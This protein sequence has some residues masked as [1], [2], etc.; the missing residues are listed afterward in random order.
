VQFPGE[1]RSFLSVLPRQARGK[2]RTYRTFT[3]KTIFSP[4]QAWDTHRE[5]LKKE[6][7]FSTQVIKLL[8]DDVALERE[9]CMFFAQD[10]SSAPAAAAT[11]VA[12]AAA[13]AAAAAG[14]KGAG[15]PAGGSRG[16]GGRGAGAG[17]GARPSAGGALGP[18]PATPSPR[19]LSAPSGGAPPHLSSLLCLRP[20]S[21]SIVRYCGNSVLLEH[22]CTSVLRCVHS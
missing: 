18:L 15:A 19:P 10:D 21:G 11:G 4:R 16:G 1:T 7:R 8:A 5:K 3:Q 14:G 20:F 9:V 17:G 22:E 6:M 13:A 2:E 12:A